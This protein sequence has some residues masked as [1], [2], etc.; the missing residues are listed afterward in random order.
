MRMAYAYDQDELAEVMIAKHCEWL[1]L[2]TANEAKE[3]NWG[4]PHVYA[5]EQ[6]LLSQD[7]PQDRKSVV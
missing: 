4:P 3:F 2:W 7:Y 5:S 6:F 1:N